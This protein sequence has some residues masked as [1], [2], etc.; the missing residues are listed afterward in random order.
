MDLFQQATRIQQ[1]NL[2]RDQRASN[3]SNIRSQDQIETLNAEITAL[4]MRLDI[5]KFIARVRQNTILMRSAQMTSLHNHLHTVR[6]ERDRLSAKAAHL[7]NLQR[8]NKALAK[9]NKTLKQENNHLDKLNNASVEKNKTLVNQ[10]NVLQNEKDAAA[11]RALE[12]AASN[13]SLNDSVKAKDE[14]LQKMAKTIKALKEQLVCSHKNTH[15]IDK[16]PKESRLVSPKP[17]PQKAD[18][19]ESNLNQS[20]RTN[21]AIHRGTSQHASRARTNHEGDQLDPFLESDHQAIFLRH[22]SGDIDDND[23]QFAKLKDSFEQSASGA[24]AGKRKCPPLNIDE[25]NSANSSGLPMDD[26][27]TLE[28]A[29]ASRKAKVSK[30]STSQIS[31]PKTFA[32]CDPPRIT[33]LPT[34]SQIKNCLAF[35]ITF[36]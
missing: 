16:T 31:N 4:K 33:F 28:M 8:Q 2:A 23:G 35:T 15:P 1:Q 3:R 17:P 5:F 22:N 30:T 29:F 13:T 6:H 21:N 36:Q 10:N 12:L 27:E 7:A 18:S 11:K 24:S 20:T 25:S 34:S 19:E 32:F 14:E 9:D 26:K